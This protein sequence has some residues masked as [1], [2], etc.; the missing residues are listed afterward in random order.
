MTTRDLQFLAF[1]VA[2]EAQNFQTVLQRGRDRVEHVRR[3]DE[4]DFGEIVFNVQIVILKR[5]V[6]FRV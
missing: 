2:G 4:E 5:I 1:G 3:R 6:L